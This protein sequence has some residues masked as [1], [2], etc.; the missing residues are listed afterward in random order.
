MSI[1]FTCP[2][3]GERH[4]VR[5][6]LAGTKGR[7]QRCGDSFDVPGRSTA[8]AAD[9]GNGPSV[10]GFVLDQPLPRQSSEPAGKP[11]DAA[12]KAQRSNHREKGE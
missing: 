9:A 11:P 5:D 1:W 2:G 6:E 3:C 10:Y 4:I 12:H 8:D 7:C